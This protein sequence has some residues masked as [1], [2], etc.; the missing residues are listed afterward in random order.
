MVEVR[1][2][3]ELGIPPHAEGHAPSIGF[4]LEQTLGHVT[5]AANL[6]SIV[7]TDQRI[8]AQFRP[9]HYGA[10]TARSRLL[11]TPNWTVRS[12]LRARRII[13]DLRTSGE[14]DALFIHTQVPAILCPDHLRRVPTVVSLDA[15]PIQYDELGVHY[16]HRVGS[17]FTEHLKWRANLACFASAARIV[18]WSR[19]ARDG[20]VDRYAVPAEQIEVIPPGVP[21]ERWSPSPGC[22]TDHGGDGPVRVL[23]VGADLVRKGGLDLLEACRRLRR[24]GHP[25]ELHVATR[26]SVPPEPG[27]VIHRDLQPNSTELIELFHRSDVFCLPTHGDCLP[28]VLSEA[29]AAG[30]PLVSTGVGAIPELVQDGRNGFLVPPGC[31]DALAAVLARLISHDALRRRLGAAGEQLARRELD[32]A[33]NAHRVV[34]VLLAVVD[35]QRAR[36]RR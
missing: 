7:S 18:T 22:R 3:P 21:R 1:P 16:E 36:S 12:G 28:M 20:L 14:L 5:H 34:D 8:A 11:G 33:T 35:E 24:S 10:G 26:H 27:V 25:V 30:L 9:V 2:C 31:P 29:S 15:T 6:T 13:G 32:A 23:F 4:V 19:W 17:R